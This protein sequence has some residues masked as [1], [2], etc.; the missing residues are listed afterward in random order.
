MMELSEDIGHRPMVLIRF[1]PDAN[2]SGPS[3]WGYDSNGLAVVKKKQVGNWKERLDEL[4]AKINFWLRTIP[5]KL[6]VINSIEL[7]KL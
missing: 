6:I 3:C 2:S 1:N 7:I 4:M 5:D